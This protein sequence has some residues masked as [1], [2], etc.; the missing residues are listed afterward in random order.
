LAENTLAAAYIKFLNKE[1]NEETVKVLEKAKTDMHAQYALG[2]Y[3]EKK[4]IDKAIVHYEA[5][6]KAGNINAKVWLAKNEH[7]HVGVKKGAVDRAS[8]MPRR[9]TDYVI[10][11]RKRNK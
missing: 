11:V 9:H 7:E 3:Y 8:K 6:A 4:K 1:M 2:V 10:P 5:A